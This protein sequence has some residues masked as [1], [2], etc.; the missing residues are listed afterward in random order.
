[1]YTAFLLLKYPYLGVRRDGRMSRRAAQAQHLTL[2][3]GGEQL[4]SR[5]G[6]RVQSYRFSSQ[7]AVDTGQFYG[8]TFISMGIHNH[9]ARACSL[10][11]HARA[12]EFTIADYWS[13]CILIMSFALLAFFF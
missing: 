5:R 13:Y 4:L 9:K 2:R 11:P 10:S 8:Y 7:S 1:M 6:E 3:C 12:N